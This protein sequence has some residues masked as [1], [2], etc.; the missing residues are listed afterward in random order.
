MTAIKQINIGA[1]PN[2]QTGDQLRSAFDKVNANIAEL[3]RRTVA[4]ATAAA[5]AELK[6]ADA[7][8]AADVADGKAVAAQRTGDTADAAARQA[9]QAADEADAKAL[10]AQASADSAGAAASQAQRSAQAAA[11]AADRAQGTADAALPRSDKG[12]PEGV[13]PLGADGAVPDEYR[14]KRKCVVVQGNVDL[15]EYKRPVEVFLSSSAGVSNL[16][17]GLNAPPSCW[18]KRRATRRSRRSVRAKLHPGFTFVP[19]SRRTPGLLGARR[20]RCRTSRESVWI[21]IR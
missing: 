19:F 8:K 11:D 10:H 7:G 9:R 14:P 5:I 1:A 21:S 20:E 2:D 4:N 15:N 12:K 6:A 16:P 17:A 18:S 3:D 13:A